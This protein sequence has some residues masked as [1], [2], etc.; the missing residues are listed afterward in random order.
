[1]AADC[2]VV[3]ANHPDSAADEVINGAGF[4]VAPSV[5]SLTE[6]LD[7]VL[8]GQFPSKDPVKRAQQYDWDTVADQ[9]E[10]VYQRAID[11]SW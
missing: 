4:L 3:A 8:D 9:A 5:A 7:A 10:A 1:M 2:T 6:T 11:G